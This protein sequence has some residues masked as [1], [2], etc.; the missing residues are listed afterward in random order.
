MKYHEK[1]DVQ[2]I[3]FTPREVSE[4]LDV[5]Y[6]Q[7]WNLSRKAGLRNG[8]NEKMHYTAGEIDKMR[9]LI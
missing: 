7:V 3:R 4:L 9:K 2:K 6:H 1:T 8:K 5:P